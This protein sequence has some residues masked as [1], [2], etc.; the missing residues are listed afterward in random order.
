MLSV[1]MN[2]APLRPL[3]LK[4]TEMAQNDKKRQQKAMKKR[5]KENAKKKHAAQTR[6]ASP[7]T[8]L[9]RRAGEYPLYECLLGGDVEESGM[10]ILFVVRRQSEHLLMAAGFVIDTFCLGLKDTTYWKNRTVTD[11]VEEF[12]SRQ[13]DDFNARPCTLE[14]AHQLV[15]GAI[16]YAR[17]LDFRPHSDF[18]ITRHFIGESDAFP[19]D[20]SLLLG[21]DGKPHYFA[22]PHDNCAKIL[23]HLDKRLGPDGY[24]FTAPLEWVPTDIASRPGLNTVTV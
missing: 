8:S 14:Q 13:V 19:R 18:R 9:F 12:R 21:K 1:R 17:A 24:T 16:D 22:G 20:E 3:K 15:Y 4:G 7:E 6:A 5:Q 2:S 23:R 10:A 11:Y